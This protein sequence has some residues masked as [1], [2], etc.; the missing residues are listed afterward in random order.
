MEQLYKNMTK[1]K[2]FSVNV[3]PFKMIAFYCKLKD[4]GFNAF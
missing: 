2:Q 1:N 4:I 3:L